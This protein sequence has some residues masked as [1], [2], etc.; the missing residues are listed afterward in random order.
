MPRSPGRHPTARLHLC[1]KCHQTLTFHNARTE[2]KGSGE[3]E[4]IE[5]YLCIHHGFF[6][7]SASEQLKPGM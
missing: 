6:H 4:Q 5:V 3:P 1:P 7:L 2:L